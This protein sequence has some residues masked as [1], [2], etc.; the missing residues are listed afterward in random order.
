MSIDFIL[1]ITYVNELVQPY[2]V[3]FPACRVQ[4]SSARY[5]GP[6]SQCVYGVLNN[7]DHSSPITTLADPLTPSTSRPLPIFSLLS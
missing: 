1:V 7:F 2:A 4:C 5:R 3:P 6:K